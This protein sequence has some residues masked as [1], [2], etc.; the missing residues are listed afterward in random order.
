MKLIASNF[1]DSDHEPSSLVADFVFDL[2]LSFAPNWFSVADAAVAE[3]ADAIEKHGSSF[4][5]NE[6][7]TVLK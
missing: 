3:Q 6:F 7:E 4:F 1:D 5:L 2:C